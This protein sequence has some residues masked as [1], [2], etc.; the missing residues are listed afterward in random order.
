MLL[1][2]G[3][4]EEGNIHAG[5]DILQ[6]GRRDPRRPAGAD[7]W[8]QD[9]FEGMPLGDVG[10]DGFPQ[11]AAVGSTVGLKSS[12]AKNVHNLRPNRGIVGEEFP[13]VLVGIEEL[14]RQVA[15]ERV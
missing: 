12:G 3:F 11:P 4:I 14:A 2:I 6:P 15:A 7:P 8:V 13:R 1:R 9:L 5:P 10:E